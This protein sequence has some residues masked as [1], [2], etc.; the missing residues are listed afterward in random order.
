M[1]NRVRWRARFFLSNQKE[2]IAAESIV[3]VWLEMRHK[4][5]HA[6]YCA[7]GDLSS[8]TTAIGGCGIVPACRVDLVRVS[9]LTTAL[10]FKLPFLNGYSL[11]APGEILL[12]CV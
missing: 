7:M 11:V 4:G 5:D 8:P 10:K 6:Q 9:S 12:T 2:E 3:R 1:I